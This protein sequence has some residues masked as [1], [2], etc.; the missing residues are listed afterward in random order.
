MT[1]DLIRRGVILPAKTWRE[2]RVAAA[3]R[4]LGMSEYI[5][6]A[7]DARLVSR[8]ATTVKPVAEQPDPRPFTP[9]PKPGRRK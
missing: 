5:R 4:G 3:E 6:E 7:V 9:A 1:D 8:E 2:I